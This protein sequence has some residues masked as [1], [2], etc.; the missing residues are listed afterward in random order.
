L[1]SVLPKAFRYLDKVFLDFDGFQ[2]ITMSR[3]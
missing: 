2:T 1:Y 3:F